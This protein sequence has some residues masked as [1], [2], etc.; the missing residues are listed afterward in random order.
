VIYDFEGLDSKATMELGLALGALV[1]GELEKLTRLA[2][3][4]FELDRDMVEAKEIIAIRSMSGGYSMVYAK[5][6]EGTIDTQK[7]VDKAIA[8]CREM[9]Q[10]QARRITVDGS[11]ALSEIA[12]GRNVWIG[13]RRFYLQ[14]GC[15]Y[16]WCFG[17][18]EH[19]GSLEE[20]LRGQWEIEPP[21][22]KK[23]SAE[24]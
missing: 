8:S 7:I 19:G 14:N 17:S 15:F 22:P 5:Y 23:V 4:S 13:E 24:S 12:L 3:F 20:V 16:S 9:R 10:R 18:L 2:R 1:V 21:E 6:L 11:R